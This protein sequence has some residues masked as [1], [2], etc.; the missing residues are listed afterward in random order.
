MGMVHWRKTICL[1][2]CNYILIMLTSHYYVLDVLI[3]STCFLITL[4]SI[5]KKPSYRSLRMMNIVKRLEFFAFHNY[6]S[7][8]FFIH[9]VIICRYIAQYLL[10]TRSHRPWVL[11]HITCLSNKRRRRPMRHVNY[12]H[13]LFVS[14]GCVV[15]SDFC[16]QYAVCIICL[17]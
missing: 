14:A 9:W 4:T 13:T 5:T 3:G 1:F 6:S 7:T 17:W 16:L 10:I 8:D 11:L 12:L 2:I 15:Y